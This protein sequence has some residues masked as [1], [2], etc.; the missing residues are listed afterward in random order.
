MRKS[1]LAFS[2]VLVLALP[3]A[4]IAAALPYTSSL[5]LQIASLPTVSL[6]GAGVAT[7]NGSGSA[8]QLT[9]LQV[10]A[11]DLAANGLV[12]P[13]T[14]P[15]AAPIEGVQLTLANAAG[16]FAG[17]GG[18]GGFG[19]AMGLPGVAKVCLFG[20]C[21]SAVANLIVPLGVVGAGGSAVASGVV[22]A[23]V[24]GAPWTTGTVT[25]GTITA[26]GGVAPLSNTGAPSGAVTLVTPIYLYTTLPLPGVLPGFA[27]LTL[28]FVPEPGTL[29]L[30]G[31]GVAALVAFGRKRA[32][33]GT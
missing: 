1:I 30:L 24:V 6:G 31:G 28:H 3:A 10:A 20:P 5:T 7:V 15:A 25:V 13:I 12:L 21:A 8:G 4:A 11:G 16:G 32:L 2:T 17:V 27:T 26:M 19:G 22:N 23:T 29:A 18:S 33:T 14:D 9:N